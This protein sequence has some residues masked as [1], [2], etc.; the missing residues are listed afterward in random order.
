M[1]G[2]DKE[3]NTE[4]VSGGGYL[5]PKIYA[6]HNGLAFCSFDK[7]CVS[8]RCTTN[9]VASYFC[10]VITPL[11]YVGMA[12]LDRLITE[13]SPIFLIRVDCS[14]KLVAGDRSATAEY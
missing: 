6:V 14:I 12:W 10:W 9:H 7:I 3:S 5:R 1:E 8:A 2:E 4:R 13:T 11:L